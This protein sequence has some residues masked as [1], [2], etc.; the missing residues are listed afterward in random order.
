MKVS[1]AAPEARP[2]VWLEDAA[3]VS[4]TEFD[5]Q[6]TPGAPRLVLRGVRGLSLQNFT[7]VKDV[8]AGTAEREVR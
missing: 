2:A 4:L 7:G 6:Q 8:M 3:G 5:A 1:Y